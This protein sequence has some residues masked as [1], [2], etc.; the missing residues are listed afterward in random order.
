MKWKIT[1]EISY[2]DY[3]YQMNAG[4]LM[5]KKLY[6]FAKKVEN[7]SIIS[8]NFRVLYDTI[9]KFQTKKFD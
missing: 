7:K 8:H 6:Y 4:S 2:C 5:Q 3:F 9:F 1:L